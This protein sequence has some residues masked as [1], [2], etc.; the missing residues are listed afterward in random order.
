MKQTDLQEFRK[1][2]ESIRVA[3]EQPLRKREEI[4]VET[5]ADALDQVQ[6]ATNR[7]MAIRQ[8]EL[9][10]SRFREVQDA[11]QRIDEGTYGVCVRCE[12]DI[13]PKRLAAVPW[14]AYCLDCQENA[15]YQQIR[16][17]KD[18]FSSNIEAE[19]A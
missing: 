7:E 16:N 15:E 10:S 17:A 5:T 11:I 13:S 12:L 3:V 14:A 8:L 4:A 19:L 6:D 18:E 9:D 2:L 1:T